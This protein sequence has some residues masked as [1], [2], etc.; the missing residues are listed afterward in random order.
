MVP[1]NIGEGL[2]IKGNVTSKGEIQLDGEIEATSGTLASH[3][4][5]PLSFIRKFFRKFS[6]LKRRATIRCPGG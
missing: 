4:M 3:P 2:T 6:K 1:S 5:R